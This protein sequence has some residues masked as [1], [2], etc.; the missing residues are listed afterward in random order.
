MSHQFSPSSSHPPLP[1]SLTSPPSFAPLFSS[2]LPLPSPCSPAVSPFEKGVGGW[3][4]R[5]AKRHFHVRRWSFCVCL[6][7]WV[8]VCA[9]VFACV[10]LPIFIFWLLTLHSFKPYKNCRLRLA[11][12]SQFLPA[13][14]A[15]IKQKRNISNDAPLL[16][17]ESVA[18]STIQDTQISSA[19]GYAE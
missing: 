11:P 3:G 19:E 2:F 5:V 1:H 8:C 10:F 4:K 14:E 13:R 15:F 7:V 16:R 6:Y 18:A 9:H 12:R 17:H